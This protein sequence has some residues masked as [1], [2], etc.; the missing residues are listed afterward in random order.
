LEYW[1]DGRMEHWVMHRYPNIPVFQ[2][3]ILLVWIDAGW[4]LC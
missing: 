1:N 3:S 4:R 2:H